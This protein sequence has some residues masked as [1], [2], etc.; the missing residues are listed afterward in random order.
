MNSSQLI[1]IQ[2][3]EEAAGS[4]GNP[5][6]PVALAVAKAQ[7]DISFPSG[8]KQAIKEVVDFIDWLDDGLRSAGSWRSEIRKFRQAKLKEWSIG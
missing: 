2:K 8:K 3:R 7:A 5:R 1:A 6:L 4:Y